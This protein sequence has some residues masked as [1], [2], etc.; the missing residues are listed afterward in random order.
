MS[1]GHALTSRLQ[2]VAE[3]GAPGQDTRCQPPSAGKLAVA[4]GQ[5]DG[6][7]PPL[8]V[9]PTPRHTTRAVS[10]A[11]E[12][13]SVSSNG[14]S[15]SQTPGSTV[16]TTPPELLRCWRASFCAAGS[17][18]KACKA[19]SPFESSDP[20]SQSTYTM[21]APAEPVA[22]DRGAPSAPSGRGQCSGGASASLCVIDTSIIP[23]GP[24]V[25]GGR[26]ATAATTNA[27][28]DK[29]SIVSVG[30]G[31]AARARAVCTRGNASY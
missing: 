17:V 2:T 26:Y 21:T 20:R 31:G 18:R 19:E 13:A 3:G 24:P 27:T 28:R 15:S 9:A 7:V 14:A 25:Q 11:P 5:L 30:R 16:T 23:P 29:R 4:G 22:R 6:E 8:I 1:I 10:D 12:S